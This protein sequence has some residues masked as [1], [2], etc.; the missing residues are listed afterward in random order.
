VS[1]PVSQEF[2]DQSAPESARQ[3][4]DSIDEPLWDKFTPGEKLAA[5]VGYRRGQAEAIASTVERLD[6]LLVTAWGIIANA[7]GG[8]WD[9]ESPEWVGAARRW[10][11]DWL[12]TGST[13]R[14]AASARHAE[15][16]TPAAPTLE[17]EKL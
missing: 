5:G 4:P 12:A 17:G 16:P 7:S 2:S 15:S 14:L 13:G 6:D 3:R 9:K 8:N 11:D 1:I 10:H